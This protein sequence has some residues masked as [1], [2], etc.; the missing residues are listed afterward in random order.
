MD[1]IRVKGWRVVEIEGSSLTYVTPKHHPTYW[2]IP[3]WYYKGRYVYT[4]CIRIDVDGT[5]SIF[6]DGMTPLMEITV[7]YDGTNIDFTDIRS[8]YRARINATENNGA[9]SARKSDEY[10]D[11]LFTGGQ[12]Y[13]VVHANYPNPNLN[14]P[15]Q[16][17]IK[18]AWDDNGM[19]VYTDPIPFKTGTWIGGKDPIERKW[20]YKEQ[21]DGKD[22]VSV[23]DWTPQGPSPE[24]NTIQ[25][26]ST[27]KADRVHIESVA[28]DANGVEVYNN[29]P[30]KTL[31]NQYPII[32][33]KA[34][35]SVRNF[36]VPGSQ[37]TGFGGAFSRGIPPLKSRMRWQ[38][39]N[40]SGQQNTPWTNLGFL[41]PLDFIIPDDATE[42]RL[43][44]QVREDSVG[45]NTNS[46][47]AWQTVET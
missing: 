13:R 21:Q 11:V 3:K 7:T 35:Y 23:D 12:N 41:D 47:L 40:A 17:D 5:T 10:V 32:E 46:V 28:I 18:P 36:Y 9:V 34:K 27:S 43:Q 25:L 16:A 14:V 20:R 2:E 30:K 6:I 33:E 22:W 45:R 4:S 8:I 26:P 39:K 42:V 24:S 1:K 19:Y 15:L 38:Y 31:S 29:G 44:F 37:V